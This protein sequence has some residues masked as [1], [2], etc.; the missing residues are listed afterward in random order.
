MLSMSM[1]EKAIHEYYKRMNRTNEYR[2]LGSSNS[3]ILLL[4][5]DPYYSLSFVGGSEGMFSVL[6]GGNIFYPKNISVS[7]LSLCDQ[8]DGHTHLHAEVSGCWPFRLYCG[9]HPS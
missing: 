9:E 4:A 7:G 5:V 8:L 1:S 6:Y 3:R 2:T